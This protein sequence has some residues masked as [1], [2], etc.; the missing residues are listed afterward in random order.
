MPLPLNI[1]KLDLQII[2]AMIEDADIS[3]RRLSKNYLFPANHPCNALKKLE[4]QK[5][6]KGKNSV[7]F[8]MLWIRCGGFYWHLS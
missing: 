2:Q 8:K 5:L 3:L 7:D 1:D 4:E 6:V